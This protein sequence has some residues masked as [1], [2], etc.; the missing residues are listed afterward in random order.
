MPDRNKEYY[1]EDIVLQVE[2]QL[3][4][5]HRRLFVKLSLVLGDMFKRAEA[6]GLTD[7]QPLVLR[8]VE[9]KDFIP[10]L[11]CLYPMQF[12]A[13]SNFSFTLE[14]WKSVLKL[15][16]LYKMAEV[17]TLVIEKMEPLLINLPSLQIHLAKT[18]NIQKWPAPALYRLTQR[19]KPLGEEDVGLVGLSD[20]LKIWLSEK[21]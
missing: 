3:F 12:P 18:Y 7:T 17:K 9:E 11:R 20:S 1:L 5:V 4:K 8:G 16:S 6:D 21:K 2:D 19:A 15:A 10:L 13:N 14:E